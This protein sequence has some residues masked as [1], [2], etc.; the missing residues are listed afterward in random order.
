MASVRPLMMDYRMTGGAEDFEIQPVIVLWVPVLM[1]SF[2]CFCVGEIGLLDP[3]HLT[4]INFK[5]PPRRTWRPLPILDGVLQAASPTVVLAISA[6]ISMTMDL[7]ECFRVDVLRTAL[8]A[9]FQ[10]PV[11]YFHYGSPSPSTLPS[12]AAGSPGSRWP[13]IGRSP[14]SS[15]RAG[16]IL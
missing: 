2:K 5:I 16:C 13:G 1:V 4:E 12:A 15:W 10:N 3:T 8:V 6:Y 9:V 11:F 7:T 14:C